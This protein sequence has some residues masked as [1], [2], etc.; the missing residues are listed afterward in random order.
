MDQKSNQLTQDPIL[1]DFLSKKWDALKEKYHPSLIVFFGSRVNGHARSESDIDMMMV[2]N[3]FQ[4]KKIRGRMAEFLMWARYPVHIDA[5]C[6]SPQE[7]ETRKDDSWM[8]QE[9]LRTGVKALEA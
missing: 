2:S 3:H 9:I 4:G 6:L 7:Y 8:I 5:W 1:S